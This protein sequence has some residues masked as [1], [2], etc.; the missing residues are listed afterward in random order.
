MAAD[1]GLGAGGVWPSARG[2]RP[3]AAARGGRLRGRPRRTG[4]SPG[5]A[6]H[7]RWRAI[8]RK[9]GSG[10]ASREHLRSQV[11]ISFQNRLW[12]ELDTGSQSHES[13]LSE[14]QDFTLLKIEL[15]QSGDCLNRVPRGT[16]SYERG[17]YE[18]GIPVQGYL[19]HKK[20][21]SPRTLP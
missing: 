21:Q 7:R 8:S 11:K 9:Y 17:F 2:L 1:G 13:P 14:C 12:E 6:S 4:A 15:R 19:A 16:V 5:G 3:P 18:R 20:T 10:T